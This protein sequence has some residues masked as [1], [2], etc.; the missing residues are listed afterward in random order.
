MK[1]QKNDVEKEKERIEKAVPELN[2][3][4]WLM[5]YSDE[6]LGWHRINVY[7]NGYYNI[8][9][10]LINKLNSIGY[11]MFYI[12]VDPLVKSTKKRNSTYVVFHRKYKDDEPDEDKP[13]SNMGWA[14]LHTIFTNTISAL[15]KSRSKAAEPVH[16]DIDEIN[17]VNSMLEGSLKKDIELKIKDKL[18]N[19]LPD[20]EMTEPIQFY[21]NGKLVKDFKKKLPDTFTVKVKFF[22]FTGT[23][24]GRVALGW[25]VYESINLSNKPEK[26]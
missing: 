1:T 26:E 23:L 22:K 5:D 9:E 7:L 12:T 17:E 13:F 19:I 15:D 2:D 16:N 11:S 20:A 21:N 3:F 4:Y 14:D 10:T 6:H 25:S 24:F 18:H 8:G